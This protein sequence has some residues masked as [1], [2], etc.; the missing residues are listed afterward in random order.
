[1][2]WSRGLLARAALI[3]SSS[4][5]CALAVC[6][7]ECDAQACV[8]PP[9]DLIAW[10]PGDGN[11]N[12]IEGSN[13][14]TCYG[15]AA[16]AAGMVDQAFSLNGTSG[17]IS[18]ANAPELNPTSLTIDAWIY[19]TSTSGFRSI[20]S[21]YSNEGPFTIFAPI[22]SAFEPIP[23]E[24]IDESFDD[25]GYLLGIINYHIVEGKYTTEDLAGLTELETINGKKLK[26][27]SGNG[28][29]VD[30]ANIIESDIECSNGIIH[31]IDEILVP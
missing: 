31:A 26:I 28:I 14:G 3:V 30:T 7:V 17:Y 19:P 22:E 9:A 1:M 5:V 25:H 12:D 13:D 21:K 11:T 6:S 18:I 20:V 29:K 23:D 8:S 15:T 2:R 16:Y 24:V 27:T 10:W 4:L